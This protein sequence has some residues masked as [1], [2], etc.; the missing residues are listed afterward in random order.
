MVCVEA[1]SGGLVA[2]LAEKGFELIDV[3]LADAMRLGVNAFSLGDERVI[4][5]AG[6]TKL[7]QR[8]RALGLEVLDPE[9]SMF[10]GGGGGAHCLAQA[11]RRDR[12]A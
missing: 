7:N 4:S 10:T 2:W 11:L 6:S 5:A 8:L 3:P 12:A 1:A 9:L